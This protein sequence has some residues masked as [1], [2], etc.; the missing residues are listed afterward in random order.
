MIHLPIDRSYDTFQSHLCMLNRN[1]NTLICYVI[2]ITPFVVVSAGYKWLCS[3]FA[4]TWHQREAHT[5]ATMVIIRS[6]V[7]SYVVESSTLN[8]N[9]AGFWKEMKAGA[10]CTTWIVYRRDWQGE[11][12]TIINH[13][14]HREEIREAPTI[15]NHCQNEGKSDALRL[16]SMAVDGVSAEVVEMWRHRK[17]ATCFPSSQWLLHPRT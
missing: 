11:V 10:V 17:L 13:C 12:P 4:T 2:F 6:H 7:T 1:V 9:A 15:I 8:R 3:D 5:T 16:W 14:Q